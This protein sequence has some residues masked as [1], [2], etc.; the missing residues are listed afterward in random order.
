MNVQELERGI[1]NAHENGDTATLAR[2]Q[3]KYRNEVLATRVLGPDSIQIVER[4][5]LSVVADPARTVTR[6]GSTTRTV[7]VRPEARHTIRNMGLTTEWESGGWLVGHQDVTS[8]SSRRSTPRKAPTTAE[9]RPRFRSTGNGLPSSTRRRRGAVG[10]SSE[11]GIRIRKA[12]RNRAPA[13]ST[14]GS[15]RQPGSTRI[16]SASFCAP[17]R[18]PTWT[19]SHGRN[20]AATSRPKPGHSGRSPST[21]SSTDGCKAAKDNELY[22]LVVD[23]RYGGQLYEAGLQLL[24]KRR[25]RSKP[26]GAFRTLRS[27]LPRGRRGARGART[28]RS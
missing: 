8:L 20:G 5:G 2:L 26:A 13:T 23:V 19:G 27:R 21:S 25:A 14:G 18:T 11:T 1:T 16:T 10:E 3:E 6:N 24:G 22:T 15:N 12:T 4:S 9:R 28:C 17:T 7:V